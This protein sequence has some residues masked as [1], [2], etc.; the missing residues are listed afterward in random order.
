MSRLTRKSPTSVIIDGEEYPINT[1]FRDCLNTVIALGDPKLS[2]SEKVEI[3][4]WN[5]YDEPPS[6][7]EEAIK[8]AIWFLACGK[9]LDEKEVQQKLCDFE[10]DGDYI[11]SA[12]L[13]K[14][15]DLDR[16]DDLHW[17][18]FMSHFSEVPESQFTRIVY[19]RS[20]SQKGKL[21]K[22]ERKECARIGWDVINMVDEETK[23]QTKK[24]KEIFE[25]YFDGE[26]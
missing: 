8:Q 26:E 22:D 1:D 5:L 6:N 16:V 3:I 25:K 17:W 14:G 21:T 10:Q 9:D 18:T 2:S 24:D 7:Y 19:L 20:Q 23:Q 11:Y 4:L 13:K 12:L 15:V